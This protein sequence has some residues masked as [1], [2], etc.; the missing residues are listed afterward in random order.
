MFQKLA[1]SSYN[2][3]HQCSQKPIR[4]KSPRDIMC[5]RRRPMSETAKSGARDHRRPQVGTDWL[6]FNG[7]FS[8]I[9]LYRAFRSY[10]L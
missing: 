5:H 7:T 4:V 2:S 1:T 8:T 10:S 3:A 9:R 6:E